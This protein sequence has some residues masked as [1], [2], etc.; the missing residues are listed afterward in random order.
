MLHTAIGIFSRL[1]GRG[2][3]WECAKWLASKLGCT[4]ATCI[5]YD[6]SQNTNAFTG[7]TSKINSFWTWRL[8][9]FKVKCLHKHNA[10]RYAT[11]LK[12]DHILKRIGASALN[13]LCTGPVKTFAHMCWLYWQLMVSSYFSAIFC[14]P[15]DSTTRRTRPYPRTAGLRTRSKTEDNY[16]RLSDMVS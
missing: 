12:T 13:G 14:L 10:D 15:K 5:G 4:L 11:N 3:T 2:R 8:P 1:L 7:A 9:W 6:V 16:R